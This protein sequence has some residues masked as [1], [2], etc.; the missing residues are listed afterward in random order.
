[1]LGVL[2]VAPTLPS[3]AEALCA[4]TEPSRRH[5]WALLYCAVDLPRPRNSPV[6]RDREENRLSYRM[7]LEE[8]EVESTLG[9]IVVV[10]YR[11]DRALMI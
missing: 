9:T 7:S 4:S 3:N 10:S 1:M 5:E 2:L 8:V 11:F 6:P